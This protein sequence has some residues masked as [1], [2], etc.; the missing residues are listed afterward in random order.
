VRAGDDG[1]AP[2]LKRDN[3]VWLC[4]V[5]ARQAVEIVFRGSGSRELGTAR[6]D[7]W[8]EPRVPGS[9]ASRLAARLRAR[10]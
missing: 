10:K 2:P 5:P 7:P 4:A 9:F 8:E 3:L 1:A 6:F